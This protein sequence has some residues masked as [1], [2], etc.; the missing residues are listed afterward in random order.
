MTTLEN[1]EHIFIQNGYGATAIHKIVN[2]KIVKIARL[3][4]ILEFYLEDNLILKVRSIPGALESG[5][6]LRH[7]EL[8]I[9]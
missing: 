3:P 1:K 5:H 7:G 4:F 9:F 8:A 2:K 6:F